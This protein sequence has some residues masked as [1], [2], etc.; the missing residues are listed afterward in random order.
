MPIQFACSHC[1]Q[2][3][4]VDDAHAGRTAACPYCQHLVRVPEGSTYRPDDAVTARPAAAAGAVGEDGLPAGIAAAQARRAE[5]ALRY[6][7]YGVVCTVLTLVTFAAGLG[8]GLAIMLRE[9]GGTP[10][11]ELTKAE[12]ERVQAAV[13]RSGWVVGT[14][15]GAIF[16]ALVGLT[17]GIVSLAQRAAANWRGVLATVICGLFVVCFCGLNVVGLA[18]GLGPP[19][20]G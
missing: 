16:F 1:D 8:L 12:T 10:L 20:P 13:M 7:T 2:P 15:L 14:Q 5:A 11:S 3:I 4:E 19:S 18:L 17:F 9:A 6:G